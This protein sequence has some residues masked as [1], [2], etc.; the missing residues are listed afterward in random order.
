MIFNYTTSD[1]AE[2]NDIR[3]SENTHLAKY[4]KLE[5][6]R[7]V[8]EMHNPLHETP[9]QEP[10]ELYRKIWLDTKVCKGKKLSI[11]GKPCLAL[12]ASYMDL[13]CRGS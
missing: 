9:S 2:R 13:E 3:F 4:H 12:G 8:H 1:Q 7:E 10:M 5:H 11:L 6:M